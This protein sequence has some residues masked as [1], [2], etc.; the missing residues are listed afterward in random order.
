MTE[1][2][3]SSSGLNHLIPPE[4]KHDDFYR[5]IQTIAQR[6]DV[7][8]ILEIGSSSGA[9][10]T[11]AFVAGIRGNASQP[12]L[13]C[14]EVSQP[15]FAELQQHYANDAFVRCYN[16]SSVAIEQFPLPEDVIEFYHTTPTNLNRYPLEQVL[17][18]LQQDIDY[19]KAAGVSDAGIQ[20]IKQDHQ[21]D[22]FDAV[23]ID[24]SEFTG[25]AELAQV[26]GAKFILLDDICTFKNYQNYQQLGSDPNYVLIEHNPN[27]RHGYAVFQRTNPNLAV[28]FFTIV[29]NGEPFIRYHIDIFKQLPFSWHWHIVEG[30]A[31]L[32][33]DTAWSIKQGGHITDNLHDRGLSKDGTTAYLDDLSRQYPDQITVY[34]QPQG[35][36]WD[37]KREM[38]NAPLANIQQECLLWQIDVDELWTIEQ[39]VSA[40]NLFIRHP[41]KTAAYYWCWYFVGQELVVS[42][43]NC[44]SQNPLQDWLRTWRFYPGCV[45][46]AHEPPRLL[47]PQPNGEWRDLAI[48]NP[49]GHDETEAE[50]L[51]FQHFAYVTPEQL[52]FKQHYY[53]Y[54]NAVAR[55]QTLQAET[56]FPVRLRQ[57]LPWV[58]DLTTV[59][60][61]AACGIVPLAYPSQGTWQ[62]RTS[63]LLQP[64][65]LPEDPVP[66]IVI[67]GVFFQLHKTGIA[68]VWKS[69][70]RAW[71]DSGLSQH[72]VVLD[73]AGTAPDIAGIRYQPIAPYSAS[74]PESDRELLQSVCDDLA[75]DLFISTYFTTPLT[76]PSVLLVYDMIPEVM[77]DFNHAIVRQ[78][79]QAVEYASHYL[80]IS[81]NTARDLEKFFPEQFNSGKSV[82]VAYCGVEPIF[83]PAAPA[84][85][86]QFQAKYGIT[87][88]YFLVM[89]VDNPTPYKNNALFF[90]AFA[91]L[92][93]RTGFDLVCTAIAASMPDDLRACTTGCTV[94]LLRLSD[95]ELAVAYSGA[96]AL[97][98]PS[99]Y[100]GFGMPVLEAMACGCPVITCAN[101]SIPEVAGEA[102]LYV[103]DDSAAELAEAL[104]D[105]Q[106]PIGRSKLI[107]AGLT[108]AKRFSWTAMAETVGAALIAATLPPLNLRAINLMLFPDWSQSEAESYEQLSAAIVAVLTHPDRQVMTLLVDV[109]TAADDFDPNLI[110]GDIVMNLLMHSET[111]MTD[112]PELAGVPHLSPVQWQAL[113]NRLTGYVPLAQQSAAAIDRIQAHGLTAIPLSELRDRRAANH[114]SGW[115]FR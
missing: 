55:W 54:A 1:H 9:G 60:T 62:F 106:K 48:V 40:R 112:E 59:D 11:A 6:A 95:A 97:V 63:Q 76:T 27:L 32:K 64:A 102:V 105:V 33:H 28:H 16:V 23:L 13:F 71:V 15:R 47:A 81:Q 44:Y 37:G 67:D 53:G 36:F 101:A 96:I 92:A 85:I 34:R 52:Q 39:L 86:A 74:S 73:R 89:S 10:S 78:K 57:Y 66:L 68:R 104:C 107:A 108:Q 100:E 58:R 87:K 94:H 91:Q 70:L 49:F 80:A 51:V 19:V 22:C 50:Q 88:P 46:A 99:K 43:R 113:A 45:W 84:A 14:L 30:V 77:A 18:W 82:E 31:D 26:Y 25:T 41:D 109:S 20:K 21:I 56:R 83:A 90:Q 111:E 61:A 5:I 29:L 35:A 72:L 7:K 38:V 75:A 115:Q 12:T 24:G 69:L 8:T 93:S 4:I 114:E 110:L 3:T 79:R 2:S 42:S 65:A 98:Y 103:A 17:G